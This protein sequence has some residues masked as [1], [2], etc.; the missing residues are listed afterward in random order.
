MNPVYSQ[1]GAIYLQIRD[2]IREDIINGVY[3]PQE[4]LPGVRDLAFEAKVNPNTMQRALAELE[5][6]GMIITNGTLG[7]VV[8]DDVS[9]IEKAR[10]DIVF[11]L[12]REYL[13]QLARFGLDRSD[14]VRL[15]ESAAGQSG[16]NNK[17]GTD[18][19]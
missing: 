1:Q 18:H 16:D 12:T 9:V 13:G 14:A 11:R 17:G 15:I 4:R 2:R 10:E 19:E 8:T 5:A 7:R 6:E 3:K